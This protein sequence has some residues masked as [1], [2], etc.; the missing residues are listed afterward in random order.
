MKSIY[1]LSQL[2][3]NENGLQTKTKNG[4]YQPFFFQQGDLDGACAIYSLFMILVIIRAVNPSDLRLDDIPR[5]GRLMLERLKKEVFDSKGMHRLGNYFYHKKYDNL[6]EVIERT[7]GKKVSVE[8]LVFDKTE[9]NNYIKENIEKSLPI[10]VSTLFKGGGAHALVAVGFE[11][12]EKDVITKIYCLDPG[13]PAPQNTYWNVVINLNVRTRGYKD[14]YITP[15]GEVYP[16][17]FDDFL[18]IWKK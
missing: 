1:L 13:Y 11:K 14:D 2:S 8:H 15:I 18:S 9:S 6:K 17:N 7:Y 16:S 3:I 5:D 12:N 4:R 10:M